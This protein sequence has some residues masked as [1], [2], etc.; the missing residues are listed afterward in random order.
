VARTLLVLS[1]CDGGALGV[2]AFTS[3]AARICL[4]FFFI[5]AA[6]CGMCKADMLDACLLQQA[7]FANFCFS[8]LLAM[9]S[10]M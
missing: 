1:S 7:F 8:F 10:M 9:R 3:S 6:P 4:H 5:F 2:M